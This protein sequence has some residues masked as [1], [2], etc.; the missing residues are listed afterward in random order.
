MPTACSTL[1]KSSTTR[2]GGLQPLNLAILWSTSIASCSRPRPRRNFGDSWNLNSTNR[3]KKTAKVMAPIIITSYRQ[4][5]LLEEVQHAS[6][7][8]TALQAGNFTSHRYLAA[9]PYA[10][11]DATT[12]PIGCHKLSNDT[13][14]RRF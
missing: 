11:A 14:A 6:P 8:A 1:R 7:L 9:V 5:M 10:I 12:T 13:S 3:A 4:P 2:V